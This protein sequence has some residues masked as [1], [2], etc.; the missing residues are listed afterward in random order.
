MNTHKKILT[1]HIKFIVNKEKYGKSFDKPIYIANLTNYKT[2]L[3]SI[4]ISILLYIT[5]DF[6]K[7]T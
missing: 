4:S 1:R 6:T 7:Q 2:N 5:C 3:Y